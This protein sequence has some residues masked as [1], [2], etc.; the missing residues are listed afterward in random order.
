MAEQSPDR[1][2]PTG[3]GERP[4]RLAAVGA[5]ARGSDARFV[6]GVA[7]VFA[8]S[9]G[10]IAV[11]GAIR[12]DSGIE[13][14]AEFPFGATTSFCGLAPGIAL[15]L[16][17]EHGLPVARGRRW[18][19][20][21]ASVLLAT[22]L[23]SWLQVGASVALAQLESLPSSWGWARVISNQLNWLILVVVCIR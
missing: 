6:V 23:A 2:R 22:A 19:A 8:F 21:A 15:L 13:V 3:A 7:T 5:A 9:T 20:L 16:A 14:L 11:T 4:S 1:E 12:P 10:V 18:T 17:I